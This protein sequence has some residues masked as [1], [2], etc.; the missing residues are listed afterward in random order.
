MC[1]AQWLTFGGRDCSR[2]LKSLGEEHVNS[3]LTKKLGFRLEM[4]LEWWTKVP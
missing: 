1:S 2:T 3:L 4:E